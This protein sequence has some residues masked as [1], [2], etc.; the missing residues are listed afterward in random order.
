[1]WW[2]GQG[3]SSPLLLLSTIHQATHVQLFFWGQADCSNFSSPVPRGGWFWCHV[4]PRLTI[5]MSWY[6]TSTQPQWRGDSYGPGHWRKAKIALCRSTL[7]LFFKWQKLDVN[8]K[9]NIWK[10]WIFVQCKTF[11]SNFTHT[12][13]KLKRKIKWA[14]WTLV[15]CVSLQ[16]D[17]SQ[18]PVAILQDLCFQ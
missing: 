4:M 14:L 10:Q 9:R 6:Q 12:D 3:F 1:M 5:H 2:N 7:W 15:I 17:A 11:F 13:G 16:V 18:W 8:M